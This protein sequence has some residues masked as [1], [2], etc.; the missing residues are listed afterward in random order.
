MTCTVLVHVKHTKTSK[1]FQW[2][3]K[4]MLKNYWEMKKQNQIYA[5]HKFIQDEITKKNERKMR[6]Q[7]KVYQINALLAKE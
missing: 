1:P 4:H 5:N 6:V 3:A 7:K 2:T